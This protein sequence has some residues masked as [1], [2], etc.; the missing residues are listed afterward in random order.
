MRTK[1]N[2]SNFSI[3]LPEE[4]LARLNH[5]AE[6]THRP[7]SYYIVEAIKEHLEEMEDYYLAAERLADRNAE[8]L[9]SEEAAKYLEL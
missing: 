7:K 3:R 5:L 9:T 4:L 6:V 2:I 8:Y 1:G